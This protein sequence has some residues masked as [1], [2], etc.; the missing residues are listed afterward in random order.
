MASEY[1]IP[2]LAALIPIVLGLLSQACRISHS[3][4]QRLA[5]TCIGGEVGTL[6]YIGTVSEIDPI[7]IHLAAAVVLSTGCA[8]LG[9]RISNCSSTVLGSGLVVLGLSLAALLGQAPV[10]GYALIGI[11]GY[12]A[13]SCFRLDRST[14]L[15]TISLVQ[16]AL[17]IV[18]VSVSSLVGGSLYERAG[19]FL[20][21]TLV[22]LPP[23]H[24]PF[25][26]LVGSAHGILA[27]LWAVVFLSLGFAQL[28]ELQGFIPEAIHSALS[29]LALVGA[30]YASL[31]SLGQNHIRLLLAYA[32]IAQISLLWGLTAVFSTFSEWGIPFG[33]TVALVM[34]GLFVAY[35]FV[36]ERYGSHDLGNLPGLA[37]P[38]PR[39]GTLLILLISLAMLLPI[40][41]TFAGLMTMPTTDNQNGSLM[42]ISLILLG[43]WMFGSWYFS[44]LLHQTAFGK[45]RPDI[46][47]TDLR[48]AEIC[49]LAVLIFGA[50]VSAFVH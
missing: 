41:P 21:V 11:L 2:V 16:M 35:T 29:L 23:F 7:L 5:L 33:I 4:F 44:H 47:Y 43:V 32:T 49:S 36:Q 22:P 26:S 18:L 34:N 50:S 38:M 28:H 20:A 17:A 25:V 27:G 37:T 14:T 24:F 3:T 1:S 45:A 13:F 40:V 46:P 31:K 30:L 9:Q 42:I 6:F 39:L 10:N 8:V 15:R 48:T 12:A 19:L